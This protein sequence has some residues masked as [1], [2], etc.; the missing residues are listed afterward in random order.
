MMDETH[1]DDMDDFPN[2]SGFN[3]APV[4]GAYASVNVE[5]IPAPAWMPSI[6]ALADPKIISSI[7]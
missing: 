1:N 7:Q 4:C 6:R 5:V 2:I 3:T